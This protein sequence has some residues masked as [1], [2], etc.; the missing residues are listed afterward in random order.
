MV[1]VDQ[2]RKRLFRS[3]CRNR[4][5]LHQEGIL[6]A[7]ELDVDIRG[8][9]DRPE[10]GRCDRCAG[11]RGGAQKKTAAAGQRKVRLVPL[12]QCFRSIHVCPR[13][14]GKTYVRRE[15]ADAEGRRGGVRRLEPRTGLLQE[16]E[17]LRRGGAAEDGVAVRKAPEARDDVVVLFRPDERFAVALGGQLAA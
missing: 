10:S 14:L 3:R 1:V 5:S 2:G 16:L 6:A 15:R 8:M 11:E 7:F 12:P 17:F 9:P 13:H 4:V